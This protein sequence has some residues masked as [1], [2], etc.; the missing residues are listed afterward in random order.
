MKLEVGAEVLEVV[1][2]G[3]LVGDVLLQSHGGLVC[4]AACDIPDIIFTKHSPDTVDSAPDCVTSASK[5][6]QREVISLHELY[7]LGVTLQRQVE[8]TQSKK[9]LDDYLVNNRSHFD[10]RV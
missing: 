7:T 2:V 1:V 9:D 5:Q 3:Q 8:A 10:S 4:P 6:H